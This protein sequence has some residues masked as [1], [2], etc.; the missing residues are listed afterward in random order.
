MDISDG[1][2]QTLRIIK[3]YKTD[4]SLSEATSIVDDICIGNENLRN[5][6]TK[7]LQHPSGFF[8]LITSDSKSLLQLMYRTNTIL[9]GIQATAFLFFVDYVDGAPWD[10]Y[11]SSIDG[12]PDKFVAN[13]EAITIFTHI[14]YKYHDTG[15]TI[16]YYRSD[17]KSINA[18]IFIGP[19]K[20]MESILDLKYSYEQTGISA[21]AAISF[22]P[23]LNKLNQFLLFK[24]NPGH[25]SYSHGNIVYTYDLHDMR[26]VRRT[27]SLI[28]PSIYSVEDDK[29]CVVIFD[30]KICVSQRRYTQT[31][32]SIRGLLYSVFNS[33]T[34]YLGTV[35]N[36]T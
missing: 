9:G 8:D 6:V 27:S 22:W 33:S 15:H 34:K 20:C 11:C 2:D 23:K 10:F 13:F 36:M 1:I 18:R 12:N 30:N 26:R 7:I 5:N 32:N 14:E 29:V 3:E 24:S 25:S 28:Q 19:K 4:M 21:V 16:I 17:T 31:V 35:G